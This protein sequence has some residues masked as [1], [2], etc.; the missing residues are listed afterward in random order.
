MVLQAILREVIHIAMQVAGI[1]R[2][3]DCGVV[4]RTGTGEVQ[5]DATLAHQ[6]QARRVDEPLGVL[7]EGHMHRDDVAA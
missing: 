2:S 1:Q 7:I 6:G 4:H 3:D 5:D